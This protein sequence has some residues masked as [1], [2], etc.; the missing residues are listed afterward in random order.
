MGLPIE[1]GATN[2]DALTSLVEKLRREGTF[3]GKEVSGTKFGVDENGVWMRF[4]L[5]APTKH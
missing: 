5:T 3:D 1:I 4:V 2:W